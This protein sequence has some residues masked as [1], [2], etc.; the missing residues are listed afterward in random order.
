MLGGHCPAAAAF[1]TAAEAHSVWLATVL[2]RGSEALAVD[3]QELDTVV[4]QTGFHALLATLVALL[5]PKMRRT[6]IQTASPT[7]QK[8]ANGST[9]LCRSRIDPQDKAWR[10]PQ[11]DSTWLVSPLVRL[12]GGIHW[13][14]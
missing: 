7:L 3:L 6:A 14:N 12:L 1:T 4:L 13:H 9:D 2:H 11:M 8:R 10:L 5:Q